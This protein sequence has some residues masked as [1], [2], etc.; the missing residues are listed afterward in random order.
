MVAYWN[1]PAAVMLRRNS[2]MISEI[3]LPTA[4]VVIANVKNIRHMSQRIR[5]AFRAT[6][7]SVPVMTNPRC[8]GMGV[9]WWIKR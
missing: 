1:A 9:G 5:R 2:V 7:A 8:G 3:T 6:L 4:S